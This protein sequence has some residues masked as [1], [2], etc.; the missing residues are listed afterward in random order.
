[1][2]KGK[3]KDYFV[4]NRLEVIYSKSW[5]CKNLL[6]FSNYNFLVF[7]RRL[8]CLNNFD[9]D[10]FV[11]ILKLQLPI[12]F[13]FFTNRY[14]YNIFFLDLICSYKGYR[15]CQGLPLR[16]Q[17]TWTNA[18][19]TYKSNTALRQFRIYFFK[20]FIGTTDTGFAAQSHL[21]EQINLLW[22]IQ[23][24]LEWRE[25]RKKQKK[26]SQDKKKV[27]VG[28]DLSSMSKG[29]VSGFTRRGSAAKKKIYKQKKNQFTL[30]FDV[31]FSKQVI[32]EN[33]VFTVSEK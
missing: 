23:W 31:G 7:K 9:Y 16:G 28:V 29:D 22:K 26:L 30:G 2:Y 1:M 14:V 4:F 24:D 15:H 19:S 13:Y 32:A 21:A 11:D 5:F 6:G 10:V 17:R 20:K 18:N 12:Y 25:A 3:K 8:E 33:N 27:A